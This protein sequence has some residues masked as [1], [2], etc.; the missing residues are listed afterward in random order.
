VD[1]QTVQS[2]CLCACPDCL[3]GS[4][5][6]T[7]PARPAGVLASRLEGIS[8][9]LPAIGNE[10]GQI[11]LPVVSAVLVRAQDMVLFLAFMV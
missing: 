2:A 6:Q 11:L 4:T 5:S 7:T 10:P 8:G 9:A 3:A 1:Q